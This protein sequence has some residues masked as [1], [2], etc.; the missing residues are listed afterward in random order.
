ML[1]EM[2][3]IIV[4]N[5]LHKFQRVVQSKPVLIELKNE[6]GKNKE[7]NICTLE[8]NK[9]YNLDEINPVINN[10]M[11]HEEKEILNSDEMKEKMIQIIIFQYKKV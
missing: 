1:T 11:D 4:Y 7:N 9:N 2:Y 6:K 5:Q 3:K 10:K 8:I